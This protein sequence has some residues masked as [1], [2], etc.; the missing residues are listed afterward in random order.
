MPFKKLKPEESRD[1]TTL[2]AAIEHKDRRFRLFQM[3]FMVGTFVALI[4]IIGAQQR[5]LDGVR[6]Q[7]TQAQDVAKAQSKQTNDSQE[8]ILRRLDCLAVYF[9]QRNR[10]DLTIQDIN[11]C[12]LERNGT[13]QQFFTQEPGETPKTTPTEQP[14]NLTPSTL[15]TRESAQP[16]Q[17]INPIVI[18]PKEDDG[19]ITLDL[20]LIPPIHIPSLF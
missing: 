7:L 10:T 8:T 1:A 5:T 17:P 3:L 20:P 4:I 11:K 6:E 19:G 2:I 15:P 13:A 16:N 9:S 12:T 18:P 14:P